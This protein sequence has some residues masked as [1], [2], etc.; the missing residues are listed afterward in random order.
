MFQLQV[1]RAQYHRSFL[2]GGLEHS[3]GLVRWGNKQGNP[4][5]NSHPVVIEACSWGVNSPALSCDCQR[6][7]KLQMTSG[8]GRGARAGYQEHLLISLV[9]QQAL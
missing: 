2:R 6:M 8:V 4:S 3:S 1:T 7:Q 9:G 5:T